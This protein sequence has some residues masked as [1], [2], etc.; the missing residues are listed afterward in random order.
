MGMLEV[1]DLQSQ[2]RDRIAM[3]KPQPAT[4]EGWR[5]IHNNSARD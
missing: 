2:Y 1:V 5:D 3:R 4:D